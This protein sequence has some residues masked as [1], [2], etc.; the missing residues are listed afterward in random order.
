MKTKI[1]I[2]I[3]IIL[4]SILAFLIFGLKPLINHL[5]VKYAKIEITLKEDLTLNFTEKKHVSDFIES[6]NGKIVDDYIIDSTKIGLDVSVWQEDIDF[7]A[8]KNAG[9]EFII[10]R[11]GTTKGPNGEYMLDS[12]FTRNIEE[13]NKYDIDVGI[14]FYSYANSIEKAKEEA[15]WVIDHIKDYKVTLPVAFDWENWDT[16]NNYN[17]SFFELTEMAKTFLDTVK[18]AG[19]DGLLYSSMNYLENFWMPVEYDTWLAHY[20]KKTS[21][22]GDYTYWQ[23]CSNGKVDGIRG[24]VDI[25]I[26]YLDKAQ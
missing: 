1:K 2:I 22:K 21:Y 24:D 3:F 25:N 6:I 23:L 12:K 4:L 8:I 11:V 17:V 15:L 9:V 26:M 5:Q 19:Y 18:A 14:Y 16:F 10:I 13:A 20:T 7:E